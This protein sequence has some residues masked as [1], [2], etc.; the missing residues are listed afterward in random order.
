M[1]I[2]ESTKRNRV[3]MIVGAT[4]LV[5]G[6]V[7]F[8]LQH[9]NFILRSVGILSCAFGAYQVKAGSALRQDKNAA[10]LRESSP[11]IPK[12]IWCFGIF[13]AF[14]TAVSF[15]F[16]YKDALDGYNG[17]WQVY[18]FACVAFMFVLT[19]GYITAKLRK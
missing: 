10:I 17:I 1:S 4:L 7:L 12:A 19:W 13:I 8:A 2:R 15:A 6:G 18:T 16:L 3:K 11:S 14:L 9:N 5:T